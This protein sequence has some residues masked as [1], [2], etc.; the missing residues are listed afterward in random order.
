M[1]RLV[2]DVPR[3]HVFLHREARDLPPVQK[4]DS[5]TRKLEDELFDKLY[6]GGSETAV[7]NDNTEELTGWAEKLHTLCAELPAFSRLAAECLGDAD[8]A[9]AA[10]ETLMKALEPHLRQQ[11]EEVPAPALRRSVTGACEKSSQ[12]IEQ[13]RESMEGLSSVGF[14]TGST[15][16]ARSS[17]SQARRLAQRLKRDDRLARI[18]MLAGKFKRIAA[19]KQKAKVRHG[20]DEVSDVELGANLSRLLPSELAKLTHP[21]LRKS[22]LASLVEGRVMQYRLQGTDSLGRG[23]LVVCLDKSGSMDGPKDI[24]ATAVALALLE[25]AHRQR[26]PFALLCFDGAVKHEARVGIGEAL[27]EQC[28]FVNAGGGTNITGVLARALSIIQESGGAMKKA[29]VVIITDGESETQDA[30]VV[31]QLAEGLGATILGF[32]IGVDI[33][34]LKPWCDEVTAIH[35][36]DTV[37]EAAAEAAFTI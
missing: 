36:L 30:P 35:R 11:P 12:V 3:W 13:Q 2:H 31:R 16:G 18:A 33:A 6:S 1:L 32:G 28:L 24:W 5:A 4:D 7:A 21:L 8:A 27:P 34:A 25:V 29:D 19:A 9:G 10:V 15:T 22:F 14:G 37:E 26:R 17:G 23:P 20:A